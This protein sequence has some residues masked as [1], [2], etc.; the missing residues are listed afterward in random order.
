VHA[1]HKPRRFAH[2]PAR[3]RGKRLPGMRD[4]VELGRGVTE[5]SPLTLRRR[6]PYLL[7][8]ASLLMR[9]R[10]LPLAAALLLC[11]RVAVGPSP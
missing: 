8:D 2:D 10:A 11:E 5:R 6:F 9:P 3:N 4:A 1:S 7:T